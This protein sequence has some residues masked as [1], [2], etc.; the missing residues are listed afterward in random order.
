MFQSRRM[1]VPRVHWGVKV[2]ILPRLLQETGT[3]LL[4][5]KRLHPSPH[6]QGRS[7]LSVRPPPSLQPL[8]DPSP[9]GAQVGSAGSGP[10][11]EPHSL[12]PESQPCH[13]SDPEPAGRER[14]L[15]SVPIRLTSSADTLGHV[16]CGPR[17]P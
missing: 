16:C 8:T 17:L 15:S 4:G 3:G 14:S 5:G 9:P 12:A 6:R 7:F 10:H 1:C 2:S 11:P 13:S